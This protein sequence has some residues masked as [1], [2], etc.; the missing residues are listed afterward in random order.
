MIF[1]NKD[2]VRKLNNYPEERG[3]VVYW[4]SRDQRVKDN[5]ALLY[6]YEKAVELKVPLIVV[7]CLVSGFL[8]AGFRQ[9]Q[10]MLSGMENVENDLGKIG[11]KF[12]LI[13]GKPGTELLKFMQD[14]KA[15]CLITDFDPL[16]IKR[17]WKEEII[18]KLKIAFYEVDAH[19]IVPCWIA[20]QKEEY[21]AY[22]LRPKI[23]RILFNYLEEFP[24]IEPMKAP[25]KSETDW[26]EII[27][28]LRVD[29]KV[30]AVD[31]LEAGERNASL[32]MNDFIRNKLQFYH[33]RRNDPNAEKVSNLSAYLHFGQIA[34]Q[35]IALE[36]IHSYSPGEAKESFL[37]E[38]IIRK[39]LSDNFCY[40]NQNYD[41][42]S[43]FPDWAKKT[44]D[45][46]RRNKREYIYS[47]EKF[48]NSETH[49]ELW[50]AAQNEM[51]QTGKMH[52]YLRMYWAKKIL[53]WS[54]SPEDAIETAIYLND[55]Y[56]LDGRDANGYTG[57]AWSIGGVHDRAWNPRPVFGKIRYMSYQGCKSKFDIKSYI[58]KFNF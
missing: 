39:E 51:V 31:W 44:L 21:S 38:L 55:K 42:F 15:G 18:L 22:T 7:F 5:W 3:P 20:S 43:G 49:D 2:R 16:K 46:H 28:K 58:K 30:K 48:E 33:I 23:S 36:I 35:R 25:L 47:M 45:E 13:K 9:Y 6:G 54:K 34:S 12:K 52:G 53:E 41:N 14:T 10:F 17:Q 26:D 57:I 4:M 1:V 29:R 32:K 8:G 27:K 40:Y 37:E 56:S 19:N 24:K 50:N 11:I